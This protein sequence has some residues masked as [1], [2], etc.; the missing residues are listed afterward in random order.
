MGLRDEGTWE[1]NNGQNTIKGKKKG[2]VCKNI[3][4]EG[5]KMEL[6]Q[7][8]IAESHISKNSGPFIKDVPRHLNVGIISV[9]VANEH[10]R[11][12]I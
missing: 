6:F 4:S 11:K 8:L 10:F 1:L 5:L 12:F 7:I 9:G 2:L 3:S